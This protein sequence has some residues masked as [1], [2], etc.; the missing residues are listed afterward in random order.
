MTVVLDAR[1]LWKEISGIERYVL[2]LVEG[3]AAVDSGL[4]VIVLGRSDG[5]A[6]TAA[7]AATRRAGLEFVP[8]DVA[9]RSPA[10]HLVLP[11]LLQRLGCR[12]YHS[13]Y[14]DAPLLGRGFATVITLHDMTPTTRRAENRRSLKTVFPALWNAW[15]GLQCGRAAAIVTVSEF[16]K[17]QIL[18]LTR[19]RPERVHAIH[20]GVTVGRTALSQDDVRRRFRLQGRIVSYVGRQDPHKN[21]E[22]LVRAFARVVGTGR[23]DATLVIAGRLD[24]RYPEAARTA[25]AL[26]L[27]DRVRFTGYIGEDERVALLRAS[28][29]FVF[30]SRSEG[31]GFPPLEAMAEGVP[32][33]ALRGTCFPEILA[34]AA[35]LVDDD[36]ERLSGAI[37]SL[38]EDERLAATYRR[39]GRE[40]AAGFTW[41]R[42]AAEHVRIYRSLLRDAGALR[43]PAGLAVGEAARAPAPGPVATPEPEPAAVNL[44]ATDCRPRPARESDRQGRRSRSP[45]GPRLGSTIHPHPAAE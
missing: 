32:V 17:G 28:S 26:G 19:A 8:C 7:S 29:V 1:H 25:E 43:L 40:R 38:L 36:A 24:P 15:L 13:P 5:K 12:V 30:P 2:G 33:V 9:V 44:V 31:F 10:N 21:L 39:R 3:L 6:A 34:D 20:N 22:T 4:R 27:G 41:Q 37:L 35:V 11:R 14:V 23:T 45:A 18:G 16:S 42:S